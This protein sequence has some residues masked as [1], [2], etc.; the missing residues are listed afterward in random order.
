MKRHF[1]LAETLP[2]SDMV[3]GLAYKLNKATVGW[4][5]KVLDILE[6]VEQVSVVEVSDL[7]GHPVRKLLLVFPH[8]T[9]VDQSDQL[10]SVGCLPQWD[11]AILGLFVQTILIFRVQVKKVINRRFLIVL[12][13]FVVG[14]SLI[15]SEVLFRC[16]IVE[17]FLI[18]RDIIALVKLVF[19]VAILM[20][21]RVKLVNLVHRLINVLLIANLEVLVRT[22]L[23]QSIFDLG[24]FIILIIFLIIF[25]FNVVVI[26]WVMLF[27]LF[28]HW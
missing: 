10:Q 24:L 27:L 5:I 4:I 25:F 14:L 11:H 6:Y 1:F 9:D 22:L 3:W 19:E 8:G 17:L 12:A 18:R 21:F 23:V 2:W 7:L 28:S 26:F 15:L 13:M 20:F 16:L